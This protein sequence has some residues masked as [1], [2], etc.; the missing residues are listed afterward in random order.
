[1]LQS[2]LALESELG[3]PEARFGGGLDGGYASGDPAPGFGA[4]PSLGNAMP[5]AGD[6]DGSQARPPR[7]NR[8]DNFRFS[9]N[10]RIDRILFHQIIGTVTDAIYVRPHARARIV[11]I[12]P[13]TLGASVAVVGSWA[14]EPTSTPS[15]K[16]A[17]GVE[18]DS[19]LTYR[20]PDGFL[21]T[22]AHGVFVPGAA[23]DNP[24]MHMPARTAQSIELLAGYLF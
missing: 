18:L 13:G 7:D 20:T 3:A 4:Y 1:M 17:L 23:F 9:P 15:G 11:D 6:L 19:T 2:G 8:I 16:R 12:G 14:V 5:A 21:A 22:L 10:Y 24:T